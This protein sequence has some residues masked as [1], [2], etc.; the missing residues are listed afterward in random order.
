M[1]KKIRKIVY[2]LLLLFILYIISGMILAKRQRKIIF[3]PVSLARDFVFDSPSQFQAFNIEVKR[4]ESL[5][6]LHL[7][8]EDTAKGQVLY[9][10]GN[11]GNIQINLP[12]LTSFLQKV[13]NV[14][15]VVYPSIEIST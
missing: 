5:N 2:P 4:G 3:K 10:H 6:I 1:K 15:I 14:F 8:R 12:A 9:F 13:Y 11:S 7:Y